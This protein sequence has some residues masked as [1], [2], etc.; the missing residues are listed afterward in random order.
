MKSLEQLKKEILEDG[1]IDA[2]EVL[3]IKE[4]I[5]ADGKIDEEEANFLFELNDAVSGKN[6]HSSW[7]K[8]FI[9]AITSFVLEDDSSHGEVD[10][11]EA[12]YLFKKIKG[13][14]Q[15]DPIEKNLLLNIKAKAKG[16]P[17]I[18]EE[19]IN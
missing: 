10:G 13:D 7:E 14:G 17:S 3:E 19:L 16:F 2:N 18:L 6:N 8:L 5:Y 9:E 12:S 15:I 1:I 11:E 4:V